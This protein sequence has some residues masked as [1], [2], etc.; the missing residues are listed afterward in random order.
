MEWRRM[1]DKYAS[2]LDASQKGTGS[3]NTT[4]FRGGQIL[5]A[6]LRSPMPE[7]LYR[8]EEWSA[9]KPLHRTACVGQRLQQRISLPFEAHDSRSSQL[10]T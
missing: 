8:F 10:L 2:A 9:Q 5:R 4:R 7:S 1:G 6:S 3:H